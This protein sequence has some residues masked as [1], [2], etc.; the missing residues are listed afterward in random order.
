MEFDVEASRERVHSRPLV[1]FDQL[2]TSPKHVAVYFEVG[3]LAFSMMQ[4]I[5]VDQAR[6]IVWLQLQAGALAE[7]VRGDSRFHQSEPPLVASWRDLAA[8]EVVAKV[9]TMSGWAPESADFIYAADT[10]DFLPPLA[11]AID[12]IVRVLKPGGVAVLT[13]KSQR[14]TPD[15]APPCISYEISGAAHNLPS[16][17]K[18]ASMKVGR[19][20]LEVAFSRRGLD[21]KSVACIGSQEAFVVRKPMRVTY[22]EESPGLSSAIRIEDGR[23]RQRPKAARLEVSDSWGAPAVAYETKLDSNADVRRIRVTISAPA[24][25]AIADLEFAEHVVNQQTGEPTDT[26]IMTG[27]DSIAVS[28]DLGRKWRRI[29]LPGKPGLRLTNCFTTSS[30]R[31]IVQSLGWHGLNDG[32]PDP[33]RHGVIFVFDDEWKLVGRALAGLSNWHGTASIAQSGTTIMYGDYFNNSERY[34]ADF[35]SRRDEYMK[36]L[37]PNAIWKS[38]DDGETWRKTLERGPLEL[39]HF[40]TVQSDPYVEDTWWVTSG[41]KWWESRIW[42]STDNGL[43]WFEQTNSQP[44]VD[45]PISDVR[46][47]IACQRM[48][49]MIIGPDWLIWGSDDLLGSLSSYDYSLALAKRSG[50]RVYRSPKG[51]QVEPIEIGYVG[52][53]IRKLVDVGPGWLII[54]EAKWPTVGLQPQVFF[55]GKQNLDLTYLFNVDNPTSAPTGFTYSRGS[56]RAKDGVFF[57]YKAFGDAIASDVRCLRWEV[58][59]D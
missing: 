9:A 5:A 57:T 16:G 39:R 41:D 20:W 33:E 47:R 10:L 8:S 46:H 42:K 24:N 25:E 38:S 59:F 19:N 35:E 1:T 56:N 22:Q 55:L 34:K 43:S 48:T 52:Q 28:Y 53:P 23:Y 12:S 32:L 29:S 51:R 3:E 40:H 58:A 11:D 13:M 36:V 37:R 4:E 6:K 26:V 54:T 15:D 49:D 27:L 18:I 45:L 31:H 2:E 30:G 50:S 17:A 7:Q 21:I 14:L 44:Q